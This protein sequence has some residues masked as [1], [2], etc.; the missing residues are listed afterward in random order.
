[1]LF[2]YK[3]KKLFIKL[4]S[5]K[6]EYINNIK[7]YSLFSFVIKVIYFN[8]QNYRLYLLLT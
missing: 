3:W 7:V 4:R 8:N 1:M 6:K 2:Y 5:K